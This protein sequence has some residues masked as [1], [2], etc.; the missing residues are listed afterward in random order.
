MEKVLAELQARLKRSTELSHSFDVCEARWRD[1]F[2]A[3]LETAIELIKDAFPTN[4]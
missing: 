1:G 2:E 4:D 3:G